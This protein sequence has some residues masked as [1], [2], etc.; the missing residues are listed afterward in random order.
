MR[1][2]AFRPLTELKF[3]DGG[4]ALGTFSG[5]GAVFGNEDSYGDVIAKGAFKSS[6]R[7][8]K[9]N[10]GKFPPMLLPDASRTRSSWSSTR[11]PTR[12]H[13]RFWAS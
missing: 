12:R 9:K 3:D 13:R 5:Y 7:E 11:S 6:L 2:F 4:S 1:D 8:W 10:R